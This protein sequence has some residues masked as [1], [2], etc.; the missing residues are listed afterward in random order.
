MSEKSSDNRRKFTCYL[1]LD[2]EADRHA[3]DVVESISQ[4]VRGDFLRNAVITT[5]ALHQLDPRLPV[6]LATLFNGQLTADQLVNLLTQTTGWKPSQADIRDVI[7]S[8]GAVDIA[9]NEAAVHKE[10]EHNSD[11]LENI[12]KKMDKLI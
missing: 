9:P 7:A 4:R 12:R 11:G 8:L 3:L 6:L 2:S 5:A 10:D 1:Q